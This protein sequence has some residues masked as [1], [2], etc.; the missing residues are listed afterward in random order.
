MNV[1][2]LHKVVMYIYRVQN[3]NQPLAIF[4]PISLFD[5]SKL[6]LVG[7]SYCT[8]AMEWLNARQHFQCVNGQ[9]NLNTYFILWYA[10]LYM[11]LHFLDGIKVT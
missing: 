1:F 3:S 4:Q 9:S 7:Q 2:V 5:Q 10:Q 11:S 8:F 6:M